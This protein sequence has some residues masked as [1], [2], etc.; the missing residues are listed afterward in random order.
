MITDKIQEIKKDLSNLYEIITIIKKSIV[1]SYKGD[2]DI[3]GKTLRRAN[4][5]QPSLLAYYDEI[6]VNLQSL[7]DYIEVKLLEKRANVLRFIHE[8]SKFEYG[9]RT[10]DKLIEDDSGYIELKLKKIVVNEV[11]DLAKAICKQ[12]EQRSYSL[13]NITKLVVAQS[14]DDTMML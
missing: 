2:I 14:E 13:L 9:E 3:K 10:V 6:R 11:L 4:V 7:N 12:F 8:N 5:E 1:G